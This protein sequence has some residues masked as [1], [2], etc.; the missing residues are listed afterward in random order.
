MKNGEHTSAALIMFHTFSIFH[1][2]LFILGLGLKQAETEVGT[3][4]ER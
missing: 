3:V 1:F 4:A 2:P